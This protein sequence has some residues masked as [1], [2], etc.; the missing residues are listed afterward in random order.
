LVNNKRPTLILGYYKFKGDY[1]LDFS[2]NKI[3]DNLYW[4]F[5]KD[6]DRGTLNKELYDF[7]LLCELRLFDNFKY[8]Y[9]DPFNLTFGK[10]KK[11]IN[12]FIKN[13]GVGNISDSML[14][15][16]SDNKTFGFNLETL[17]ICNIPYNK[18]DKLLN[19]FNIKL[20]GVKDNNKISDEFGD[21]TY[22]VAHIPFLYNNLT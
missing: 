2:N 11:I 6:E 5:S 8:K 17:K 14:F 7:M 4:T 16:Y 9:V 10:I 21:I 12:F 15:I 13:G 18:I 22:D 1:E 20:L 3:K 19:R